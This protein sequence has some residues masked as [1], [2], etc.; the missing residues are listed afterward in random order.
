MTVLIQQ[1]QLSPCKV[2]FIALY[3]LHTGGPTLNVFDKK[4][5]LTGKQDFASEVQQALH[6]SMESYRFGKQ[7][8]DLEVHS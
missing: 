2:T 4:N 5:T 3:R 8:T 6:L 1:T 7:K